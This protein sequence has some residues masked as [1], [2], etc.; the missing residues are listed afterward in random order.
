MSTV[1]ARNI[2]QKSCSHTL[3]RRKKHKIGRGIF[4]F[5]PL[6]DR[7]STSYLHCMETH[8]QGMAVLMSST[9]L[10]NYRPWC[11]TAATKLLSTLATF[12]SS[13]CCT[14]YAARFSF[15]A[16]TEHSQKGTWAQTRNEKGSAWQCLPLPH[17]SLAPSLS[18]AADTRATLLSQRECH[19]CSLFYPLGTWSSCLHVEPE[20]RK[21]LW[22]CTPYL[23]AA[24]NLSLA[25]GNSLHLSASVSPC[26]K[27]RE[28]LLSF[29][30]FCKD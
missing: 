24:L 10:P 19:T 7:H 30:G 18:L 8:L 29:H 1:P 17:L 22:L 6:D 2:Y 14:C 11:V 16:V 26:V 15:G 23:S 28:C 20:A 13:P 12:C 9:R 3:L 5:I 27:V 25:L 21:L 4:F